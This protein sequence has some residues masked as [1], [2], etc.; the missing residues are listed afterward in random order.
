[1]AMGCGPVEMA[2]A[3]ITGKRTFPNAQ[4]GSDPW[5]FA[6]CLAPN[7]PGAG[8]G[9]EHGGHVVCFALYP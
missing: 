7:W 8:T 6:S 4:P 1:M 2:W 3:T 5:R 9:I